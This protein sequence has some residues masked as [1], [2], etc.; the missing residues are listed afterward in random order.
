MTAFQEACPQYYWIEM[1]LNVTLK[2]NS[3]KC[4]GLK[5]QLL[6]PIH[7]VWFDLISVFQHPR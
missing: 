7:E 6:G 1:T 5:E 2:G 4:L 3:E